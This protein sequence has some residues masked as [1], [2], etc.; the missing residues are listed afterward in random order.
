MLAVLPDTAVREKERKKTSFG[1]KLDNPDF[2]K[3]FR[4]MPQNIFLLAE[5]RRAGQWCRGFSC[6]C[7]GAWGGAAFADGSYSD[8]FVSCTCPHRAAA[9][10]RA[11]LHGFSWMYQIAPRAGNVLAMEQKWFCELPKKNNVFCS[12]EVVSVLFPS[13]VNENHAQMMREF[14]MNWAESW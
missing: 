5:C 9:L 2:S 13:E 8:A 3:D 7:G 6:S 12:A 14:L 10:A 11:V 1:T 4:V